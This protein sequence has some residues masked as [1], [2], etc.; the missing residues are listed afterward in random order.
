MT[1]KERHLLKEYSPCCLRETAQASYTPRRASGFMVPRPHESPEH[2]QSASAASQCISS[3]H[4][5]LRPFQTQ[6]GW[7]RKSSCLPLPVCPLIL[8]HCE[9]QLFFSPN[10]A[11]CCIIS[12]SLLG[13]SSFSHHGAGKTTYRRSMDIHVPMASLYQVKIRSRWKRTHSGPWTR[14]SD[15]S[16]ATV[17]SLVLTANPTQPD[18]VLRDRSV[19]CR[20]NSKS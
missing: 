4:V 7:T 14:C 9:L 16:L 2:C 3:T 15:F 12:P 18:C 8:C 19:F 13:S 6:G 17:R 5:L 11:L 10:V 20:M 1:Y